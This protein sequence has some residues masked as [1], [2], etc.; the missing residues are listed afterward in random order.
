MRIKNEFK[1]FMDRPGV[2]SDSIS[3]LPLK[4]RCILVQHV[5]FR[6]EEIVAVRE[7]LDWYTKE[8]EKDEYHMY[9]K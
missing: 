4:Y 1:F 6:F 5:F 2:I 9:K 3:I 8:R 7:K